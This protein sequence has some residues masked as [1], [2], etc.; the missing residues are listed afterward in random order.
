MRG[1]RSIVLGL[2]A[3]AAL[4]VAGCGS[5]SPTSSPLGSALSYFSKDSPFVLSVVTDPNARAVKG[6]HAMI[7]HIPFATFGLAALTSQLQQRGINYDTDIR[8][9]FG[10]PV[11]VGLAG[12]RV[13]GGARSNL[14]AAWITKDAGTLSS[15][16][17]KLHLS[18]VGSHDGATLYQTS[19]LTLAVDGATVLAGGSTAS[20][21]QALDRHVKGGGL[22]SADY[23]RDL[24]TLPKDA[25][26]EAVGNLG[27]ILS[28]SPSAAKALRIPWVAALR[29]YGVA[30]SASAGGLTLQYTLQT[31]GAQL[32][33]SELPIAPGSSPPGLAGSMPIQVGLRQPA[34]TIGFI[35]DAERLS[36]PSTYAYVQAQMS[37]AQRKTGVSFQRDVLGQMG[38]SAALE[39][40]GH[41]FIVRVDV[42]NPTAVARTLRKLGSSAPQIFGTRGS[43]S[44]GPAGF[45]MARRAHHSSVLFGLVGSEFVAGTGS[46]AQLRAFASA[47]AAAAS[48]AHGAVAFRVALPQLLALALRHSPSRTLQQVLSALGDI[49]GW[50]S[51]SPGALTGSATLAIK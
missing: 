20:V 34:A 16:V 1:A 48:G 50:L 32:S 5:S 10:N 18:Q 46:P 33:S 3:A 11:V 45:E 23:N 25:L 2:A 15:L 8:P 28:S 41:G 43:V 14:L 7:A 47:P 44:A 17:K 38:N 12:P 49:T 6:A 22:N 24:G 26:I 42:V 30:V 36:S 37:A 27:G 29:G 19:G 13:S 35:L 40:D 51:S 39:S 4:V 31:T 9:L 21:D